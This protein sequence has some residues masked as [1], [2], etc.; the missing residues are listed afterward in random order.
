MARYLLAGV[1]A[2]MTASALIRHGP[3]HRAVLLD[4]LCGW[5]ARKE[6]TSVG[7]LRGLLAM[8]VDGDR[9]GSERAGYVRALRRAGSARRPW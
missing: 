5:M 7:G 4:G 8:P 1:D 3:E 9:A 2:V 6:Y